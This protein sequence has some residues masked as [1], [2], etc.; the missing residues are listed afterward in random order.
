M[1]A[2]RLL[3]P[4]GFG[5]KVAAAAA[6][7]VETWPMLAIQAA[8]LGESGRRGTCSSRLWAPSLLDA[9][10]DPDERNRAPHRPTPRSRQP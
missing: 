6:L 2:P 10:Y 1:T 9:A 4:V 7:L 5:T 3:K 8:R